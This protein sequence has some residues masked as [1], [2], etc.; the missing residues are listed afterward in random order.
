MTM[1]ILPDPTSNKLCGRKLALDSIH[2]FL[3]KKDKEKGKEK[4]RRALLNW[5]QVQRSKDMFFDDIF[6]DLLPEYKILNGL[7]DN[8][9][10][11]ESHYSYD[12]ADEDRMLQ[13]H[14]NGTFVKIGVGAYRA[15]AATCFLHKH[16]FIYPLE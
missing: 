5:L 3:S 2:K 7:D 16:R 11:G 1:E 14:F 9:D 13:I 10:D 6:G 15:A 12:G 8:W 4:T